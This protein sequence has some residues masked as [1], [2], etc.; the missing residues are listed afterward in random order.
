M[1]THRER[2]GSAWRLRSVEFHRP[3]EGREAKATHRRCAR[4]TFS[5]L[6][7]SLVSSSP[8]ASCQK[9][10][11]I[12]IALDRSF[13]REIWWRFDGILVSLKG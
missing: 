3:E 13:P 6:S 2:C 7:F 9:F 12:V 4:I 1:G 5:R 10:A 11:A 8:L